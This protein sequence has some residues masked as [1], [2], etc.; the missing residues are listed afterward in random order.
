VLGLLASGLCGI[1]A[2][3]LELPQIRAV[4]WDGAVVGLVLA[5]SLT[6]AVMYG[7]TARFLRKDD[8][9]LFNLSLLTSDIYAVIYR[10]GVQRQRLNWLY[11]VGFA[12]TSTGLVLYHCQP[13]VNAAPNFDERH[14]LL[15][16]PSSNEGQDP[17]TFE[18]LQTQEG[19]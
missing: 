18:R 17:V 1:Q 3:A 19:H 15:S 9:T 14:N 4:R 10:W 13:P 11:A 2:L 12:C 7:L 6:L 8:A 5:F 16:Q